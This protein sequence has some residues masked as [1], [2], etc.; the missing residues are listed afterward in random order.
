MAMPEPKNITD[1]GNVE[2][3]VDARNAASYLG[4]AE[5]TLAAWRCTGR[6]KL[7]FVKVGRKVMYSRSA[8]TNWMRSRT[9]YSTTESKC[10]R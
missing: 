10:S 2:D 8:L 5:Q 9:S 1:G 7:P 4:V 6:Y 3:H